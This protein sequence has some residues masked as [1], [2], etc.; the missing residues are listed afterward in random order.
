MGPGKGWGKK[1]K[2]GLLPPSPLTFLM[3][4]EEMGLPCLSMAPSATMM[5]FNLEPPTRVWEGEDGG[6][7]DR[8]GDGDEAPARA[9]PTSVS[10]RHK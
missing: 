1:K 2:G 7:H 6:G 5:M 3:S 10:L 8:D 4:S 9:R